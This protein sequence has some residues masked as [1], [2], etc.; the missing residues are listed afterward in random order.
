MS[1]LPCFDTFNCMNIFTFQ[2]IKRE[3]KKAKKEANKKKI[4]M[5]ITNAQV[6]FLEPEVRMPIVMHLQGVLHNFYMACAGLYKLKMRPFT[7]MQLEEC[8]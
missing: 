7:K 2:A 8:M 1:L 4:Q 3:K 5:T 6:G